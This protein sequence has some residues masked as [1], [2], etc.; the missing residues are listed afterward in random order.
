LTAP[1]HRGDAPAREAGIVTAAQ[2]RHYDVELEGGGVLACVLKGRST[3][4]AVGDRVEVTRVSGGGVIESVAPRTNLVYRSDAF[5]QKLLAANVTQIMGVVAPDLTLDEELIHRWMI[6]AEALP[7]RF[8]VV[9]NKTDLPDFDTLRERLA[10]VAALGY[11]VVEMSAQHDATPVLR[12]L[13]NM[14]TVLVGQSGMGKSTLI[15]AL[16]PGAG[17]RT[18]DVSTSLQ[19]GRHTTTST[20]LYRLP[21]LGADAW[22]VDSPGMKAFGLAH[23]DPDRIAASFVEVRPLLG[24][25]RFRNCRHDREPGCVVQEAVAA[26]RIAPHRIALLHSLMADAKGA[27]DPALGNR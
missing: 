21:T 23:L 13:A 5:R 11:T 6:A 16:V 25:C 7:C 18:T 10:P 4:I 3:Q 26:G 17:A 27:R 24:H 20:A 8:V 22:I 2:R 15:N 9:A 1:R 12:W 14:H 19:T